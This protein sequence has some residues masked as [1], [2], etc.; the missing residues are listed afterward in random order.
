[1]KSDR[2]YLACLRDTVGTNISF[3]CRDGNGY[4]TN[5]DAAHVYTREEAQSAWDRGR[6]IDLP[7][8]ADHV[9]RLSVW[10][11]D[12]QKLPTHSVVSIGPHVAFAK[13]CWNGNDV[14][15]AT[16]DGKDCDF[17]KAIK[18]DDV[19]PSALPGNWVLVPFE[20]ADSF[21]RRTFD[22]SLLDRRRMI[23]S[24]GLVTPEHIKKQSRRKDSGK[25]RWNCPACGKINWQHNP[26][27][28]NGCSDIYCSEWTH[29]R[30]SNNG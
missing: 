17:T 22:I 23:Q 30:E 12:S 19:I 9:D 14:Y 6:E 18:F 13:G 10:H 11:V 28:F 24:A 15:W 2:F 1:M 20:L 8:C 7:L 27:D 16:D 21:K 25:T 29:I 3:H 5:I 26:Y 4:S